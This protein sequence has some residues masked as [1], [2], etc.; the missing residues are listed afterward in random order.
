MISAENTA[1]T[2]NI[3]LGK[4]SGP[5]NLLSTQMVGRAC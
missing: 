1:I 3:V 5:A 4:L 2:V